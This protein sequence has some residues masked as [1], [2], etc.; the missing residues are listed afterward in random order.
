MKFF[1]IF[2]T[3]LLC[4]AITVYESTIPLSWKETLLGISMT[5]KNILMSTIP[6]VIFSSIYKA[7]SKIAAESITFIF[8]I[9][10]AIVTSNFLAV[11]FS[12][13]IG[14]SFFTSSA[15]DVLQEIS[16][17]ESLRPAFI[18][19]MMC[20]ISNGTAFLL[21]ILC[22]C[23]GKLSIKRKWYIILN[24]LIV[25]VIT[26]MGKACLFFLR[27][28]FFQL[29]PLFVGGFVMKLV[30]EKTFY[31]LVRFSGKFLVV[32]GISITC[33]LL[34]MFGGTLLLNS[35]RNWK[36]NLAGTIMPAITAFCTMSSLAALPFTIRNVENGTRN[37]E[38]CIASAN[39]TV[40]THMVG[41]AVFIPLLAIAILSANGAI[42]P[43]CFSYMLF[44]VWFVLTK[45]SG[46]GVPGGTIIVMIP[47]L[48]H[49]L[50][51]DETLSMMITM[52]YIVLDP[53]I[54]ACSVFANNIFI[55]YLDKVFSLIK[56]RKAVSEY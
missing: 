1:P 39:A 41:D 37:K 34:V 47:V 5:L 28:V 55:L 46:A 54:T 53:L 35:L 49:Y 25:R 45:F 33:Y 20:T 32:S 50:C 51:F 30:Y 31:N 23:F 26:Y 13:V 22:V 40:T 17:N 2:A 15:G 4:V 6:F 12:G 14:Y 48:E 7:F 36:K 27:N 21:S 8:I 19:P 42:M 9:L 24:T 18:V 56:K 29:L 10:L 43:S 3:I 16:S 44:T 38:L 52:L 11:T